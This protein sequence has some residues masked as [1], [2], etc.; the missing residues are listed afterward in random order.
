MGIAAAAEKP[1]SQEEALTKVT[2]IEEPKDKQTGA[3]VADVLRESDAT[4]KT[5]SQFFDP[6][7]KEKKKK[8]RKS[9]FTFYDEGEFQKRGRQ[10]RQ[11]ARLEEL[12][13]QIESA[14]K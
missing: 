3:L 11:K 5:T 14:T 7:F 8:E 6:R 2:K 9:M 13:N 4:I 1:I 12:Q 10:V